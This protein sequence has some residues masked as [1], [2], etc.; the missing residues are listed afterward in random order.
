MK[1]MIFNGAVKIARAVLFGLL[2]FF[3]PFVWM[4]AAGITGLSLI[5]FF[6]SLIFSD[7]MTPV[8][9]FLTVGVIAASMGAVYNIVLNLI[10]P[11]GYIG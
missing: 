3:R 6:G 11:E 5:G 10:S 1:M 9:F 8:F 4:A 7:D 2:L